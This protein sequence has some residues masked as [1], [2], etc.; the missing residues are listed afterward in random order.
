M[1][2]I[3]IHCTISISR[4]KCNKF[5]IVLQ[6]LIILSPLFL[7]TCHSKICVG[8]LFILFA[9]QFIILKSQLIVFL[10]LLSIIPNFVILGC[11]Q[12]QFRR[13]VNGWIY[14][15][16]YEGQKNSKEIVLQEKVYFLKS[17]FSS[18]VS[19]VAPF[20]IFY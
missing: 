19:F 12:W 10:S 13:A 1:L 7:N 9:C 20:S 6:T 8:I 11:S 15:F 14:F 16:V 4:I 3:I 5:I 2:Y 18:F 17:L